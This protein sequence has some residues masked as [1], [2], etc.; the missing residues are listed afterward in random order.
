MDE[1]ATGIRMLRGR[2][3]LKLDESERAAERMS[4]GG[5]VIPG[6]AFNERDQKIH[7]GTVV[8]LGPPARL[9]GK[10]GK[11]GPETPW[12]CRVGERVIFIYALWLERMRHF[13]DYAVVAQSELL[14][15]EE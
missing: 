3:L 7:R 14:A 9:K 6:T 12:E 15:V 13:E 11:E 10:R 8:A 4:D 5:I 2:A 1:L